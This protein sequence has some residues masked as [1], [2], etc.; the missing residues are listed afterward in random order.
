[1]STCLVGVESE[2]FLGIFASKNAGFLHLYC[3][4]LLMARNRGTG[5]LYRPPEGSEDVK[6]TGGVKI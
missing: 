5:W 4:K 3:E 1:M 6:R 2:N